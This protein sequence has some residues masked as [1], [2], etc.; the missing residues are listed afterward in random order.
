M[1]AADNKLYPISWWKR[2]SD[3]EGE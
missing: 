3:K 2:K 1:T